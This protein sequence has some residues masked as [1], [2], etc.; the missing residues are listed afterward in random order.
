[1]FPVYCEFL[2]E[3]Y[4]NIHLNGLHKE[5]RTA[6]Y[7]LTTPRL[8]QENTSRSV[9]SEKCK[10]SLRVVKLLLFKGSYSSHGWEIG[11]VTPQ[12]CARP[13]VVREP[14]LAPLQA[15]LDRD[16]VDSPAVQAAIAKRKECAP[17]D[18]GEDQ[19]PWKRHENQFSQENQ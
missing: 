12:R 6:F 14:T 15:V 8:I 13:T 9:Y 3:H 17:R 2:F 10:N 11:A 19:S 4:L 7:A 5:S 16:D 18:W 1:M